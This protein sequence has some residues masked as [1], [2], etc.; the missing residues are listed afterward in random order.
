MDTYQSEPHEECARSCTNKSRGTDETGGSFSLPSGQYKSSHWFPSSKKKQPYDY[1]KEFATQK[2]DECFISLSCRR[3]PFSQSPKLLKVDHDDRPHSHNVA[4]DLKKRRHWQLSCNDGTTETGMWHHP[5]AML[6][7][8]QTR[9]NKLYHREGIQRSKEGRGYL[10]AGMV[11]GDAHRILGTL[12]ASCQIF[13]VSVSQHLRPTRYSNKGCRTTHGSHNWPEHWQIVCGISGE[14]VCNGHGNQTE[15][16]L[17]S[18]SHE[19]PQCHNTLLE[20]KTVQMVI[21][22]P[23]NHAWQNSELHSS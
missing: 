7:A 10:F 12:P 18:R 4:E 3:R 15:S 17:L 2:K 8:L 19:G 1:G 13:A 11:S 14:A 20:F 5:V 23:N 16:V 22:S 9:N 21:L 6:C